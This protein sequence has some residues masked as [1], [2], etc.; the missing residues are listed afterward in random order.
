MDI[1][2]WAHEDL[3]LF[4]CTLNPQDWKMHTFAKYRMKH[5]DLLYFDQKESNVSTCVSNCLQQ[6]VIKCTIS[7]L[8]LNRKYLIWIELITGSGSLQSP[9]ML[10]TPINV[11]KVNPPIN[12]RTEMTVEGIFNLSWSSPSSEPY[13]LQYEVK[14]STGIPERVWKI[15]DVWQNSLMLHNL[16]SDLSYLI[17][18]RC[19]RRDGPGFWSDWSEPLHVNVQE[20]TYYPSQVLTTI[21][22]DV[23]VRCVFY[24]QTLT[25]YNVVWWLNMNEKIP[26]DHYSLINNHE[27]SVT[28]FNVTSNGQSQFNILQCCLQNEERSICNFRYAEIVILDTKINISCETDGALERMICR[29]HSSL[30]KPEAASNYKLK[31]YIEEFWCDNLEIENNSVDIQDCRVLRNEFGQC[32]IKPINLTFGHIMWMEFQFRETTF[33]SAPICVIPM[34]VVKPLAPSNVEA[35]IILN[36]RYLN[37]SWEKPFLPPYAHLFE[38]Q[39]SEDGI[40]SNWK[41]LFSV[42]ET[43]VI[44]EVA[45]PCVIYIARVRCMRFEGPGYKSEWSS[46]INT[47]VT[48]VQAPTM[49]PDCWRFIDNDPLT[50]KSII[51]LVWKPLTK[52]EAMCTVKGFTLKYQSKENI[53]WLEHVGDV[54]SYSFPLT[55]EIESVSVIA[56][57]SIGSSERNFKLILS[58]DS[59]KAEPVLE[60]LHASVINSSCVLL[61]WRVLPLNCQPT[62]FVIE[63][64]SLANKH[65]EDLKWTRASENTTSDCIH[66]HFYLSVEYQLTVYPIFSET[67]GQP[68]RI[69]MTINN[70]GEV[71]RANNTGMQNI[72]LPLVFLSSV[73][74]IGT[75]LISKQRIR[76]L[77]WRDVPNPNKCSWAQGINFKKS[78][79]IANLFGK[80]N[81]GVLPVASHL[82]ESEIFAVAII[83]EIVQLNEDKSIIAIHS[84]NEGVTKQNSD[85]SNIQVLCESHNLK[86]KME[87]DVETICA[88]SNSDYSKVVIDVEMD[89]LCKKHKCSSNYS[90]EG[91][92][93]G[94]ETDTSGNE[95]NN[96]WECQKHRL[97]ELIQFDE[98]QSSSITSSEGFFESLEEETKDFFNGIDEGVDFCY[99]E[100]NSLKNTEKCDTG[101]PAVQELPP[102]EKCLSLKFQNPSETYSISYLESLLKFSLNSDY[103]PQKL[104]RS[105][106]PQFQT[107]TSKHSKTSNTDDQISSNHLK[108]LPA[109]D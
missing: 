104:L 12:L 94:N 29:W 13:L 6:H 44:T 80:H 11:V 28:L 7:A 68:Y 77:V 78:D 61:S 25:N 39:Y 31:Y 19:K 106:V 76:S 23:T 45:D 73:L 26:E 10:V 52:R 2:C 60:S 22:S 47:N 18:I 86:T 95:G 90:D 51:T 36:G 40:K 107:K 50:K 9:M 43:F 46:L 96:L 67:E 98:T 85:T 54:T 97:T 20:I 49:G 53:T 59:S 105:Y 66:D 33:K 101:G 32:H 65:A 8:D 56:F 4:I 92:Y 81:K 93:S 58:K 75:F 91:V 83:E 24:N 5:R 48:D 16:K 89:P 35:E 63:W 14:Y 100:Q 15:K 74:L 42:N 1:R 108:G 102:L 27:T 62:S 99:L 84:E 70:E 57:N 3:T 34:E 38:I 41:T 72:I 30:W 17:V 64:K 103:P 21:G 37:I 87:C 71:T 79:A 55:N 109:I 69:Y 82:T 88:Q